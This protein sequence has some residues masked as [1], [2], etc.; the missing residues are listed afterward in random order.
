MCSRISP[1]GDIHRSVFRMRFE[2]CDVGS[3]RPTL[4]DRSWDLARER[5]PVTKGE[6][7]SGWARDTDSEGEEAM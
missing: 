3:W 2:G 7:W 5:R 4:M 1:E 6:V